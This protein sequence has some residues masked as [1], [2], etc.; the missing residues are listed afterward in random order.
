MQRLFKMQNCYS[1]AKKTQMHQVCIMNNV[2]RNNI[3]A[4]V[5][6]HL[7]HHHHHNLNKIVSHY[8]AF[9]YSSLKGAPNLGLLKW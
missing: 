8:G 3:A 7:H 5:I 4:G 1:S 2:R 9:L 6:F